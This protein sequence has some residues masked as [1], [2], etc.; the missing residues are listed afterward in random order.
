MFVVTHLDGLCG[1]REKVVDQTTA[2]LRALVGERFDPAQVIQ[3]NLRTAANVM[4]LGIT[5]AS[6]TAFLAALD[7]RL[8]AAILAK[9]AS[10]LH[11]F[12]AALALTRTERHASADAAGR[13]IEERLAS[14]R[15]A[16]A[17][18]AAWQ[19]R[20]ERF[21]RFVAAH[22]E[23]AA[24]QNEKRQHAI[25]A[26]LRAVIVADAVKRTVPDHLCISIGSVIAW[27][28]AALREPIERLV[29]EAF[30]RESKSDVSAKWGESLRLEFPE[31]ACDALRVLARPATAAVFGAAASDGPVRRSSA[32]VLERFAAWAL[33]RESVDWTLDR[34]N[35]DRQAFKL[36]LAAA[37]LA[38]LDPY[39]AAAALQER[40]RYRSMADRIVSD[41][42]RRHDSAIAL[43]RQFLEA[44]S[45]DRTLY[46]S[47]IADIDRLISA[48][49]TLH[50][51]APPP[52]PPSRGAAAARP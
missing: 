46:E 52:P 7:A 25:V 34:F 27:F 12:R 28:K 9:S 8:A 13:S 1:D 4:T 33:S 48:L 29:A 21:A 47:D 24:A 42:Q 43:S 5:S 20:K 22:A 23:E 49:A 51:T 37:L 31:L 36:D 35:A 16:V 38:D 32:G 45:P 50:P 40:V 2:Q 11:A 15:R 6:H 19:S 44:R 26:E 18:N 10:A 14:Y 30:H 3:A 41:V 17:A 39:V